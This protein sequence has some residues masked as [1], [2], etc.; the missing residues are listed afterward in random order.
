MSFALS[1]DGRQLVF[2]ATGGAQR[3]QY[4]VAPDGRFLMNLAVDLPASPIT[5]V[6]NWDALLKP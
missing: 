6:L 1:P 2:V 3:P 5:V 4:E